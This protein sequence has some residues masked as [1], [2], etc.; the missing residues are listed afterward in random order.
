MIV[1]IKVIACFSIIRYH[2]LFRQVELVKK[3][4]EKTNKQAIKNKQTKYKQ[5]A[6]IHTNSLPLENTTHY[7]TKYVK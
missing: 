1:I 4:N 3:T 2:S 5:S 7:H 6:Q